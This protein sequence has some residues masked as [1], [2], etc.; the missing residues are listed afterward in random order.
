MARLL[1]EGVDVAEVARRF[2]R[3]PDM[4][5]RLTVLADLPRP[6]AGRIRSVDGL[7]PLERRVLRWREVGADYAEIGRRFRRSP[8]FMQ[9]VEGLA[10]YK[11]D[12]R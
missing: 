10:Q 2:R 6:M 11:L 3:S 8:G 9:R 4:I 7:R 1:D 12:K 5:R